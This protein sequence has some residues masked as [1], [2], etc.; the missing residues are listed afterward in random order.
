MAYWSSPS[1]APGLVLIADCT[2]K[3]DFKEKFERFLKRVCIE[4]Y[5]EY[6]KQI[7][8]WYT[9]EK[10]RERERGREREML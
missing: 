3:E 5:K 10:E 2:G 4:K 1:W 7:V 9:N 6:S 8:G